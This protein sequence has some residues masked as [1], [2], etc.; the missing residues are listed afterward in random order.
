MTLDWLLVL[1]RMNGNWVPLTALPNQECVDE[2]VQGV[3][4]METRVVPCTIRL[5]LKP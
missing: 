2:A 4:P 1:V 3:A 5:E